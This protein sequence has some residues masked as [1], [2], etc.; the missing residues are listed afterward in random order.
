MLNT[1]VGISTSL[2]RC[3]QKVCLALVAFGGMAVANPGQQLDEAARH[4]MAKMHGVPLSTVEL[5]PLDPR[6]QVQPCDQAVHFDHPFASRD[7]LRARCVQPAWQLYRQVSVGA[8]AAAQ[9]KAGSARTV[10]VLKRFL[11]RGTALDPDML[12][13]VALNGPNADSSLL[14]SVHDV[15]HAELVR[16]LMPG[17]PVRSSDIRRATMVRQ[18]QLVTMVVGE[19]SS[20]QV[21]LR[22]EALQDGRMGE[23]VRLRNTESGRQISGIVS[24]PNLVRGL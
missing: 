12:E 22:V 8:T 20:F 24:G 5:V 7:T 15:V 6:I 16:D 13:E 14:S 10:V 23:Q 9:P 21:V 1:S 11:S 18:G 4:W 19:K 17:V 2:Q 3:L